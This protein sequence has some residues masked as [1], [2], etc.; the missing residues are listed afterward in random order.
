MVCRENKSEFMLSLGAWNELCCGTVA[1]VTELLTL[2]RD[3]EPRGF[4]GG[5]ANNGPCFAG[6]DVVEGIFAG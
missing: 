3:R 4:E 1:L 2:P 5:P 6:A